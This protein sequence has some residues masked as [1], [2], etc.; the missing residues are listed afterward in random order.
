MSTYIRYWNLDN[1]IELWAAETLNSE[2]LSQFQAAT[3][4]N[5]IKWQS[6]Q[7]QGLYTAR[8]VYQTFHSNELNTDIE[9]VVGQELTMAS[10]V[11]LSSLAQ[12]SNYKNWIQRFESET[13]TMI[14]IDQVE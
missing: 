2:E 11:E 10:G 9:I 1:N 3:E 5:A 14:S 4:A 6:Y 13:G 7:D 8:N 12:D